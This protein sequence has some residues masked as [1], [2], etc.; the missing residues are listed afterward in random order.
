M[1]SPSVRAERESTAIF[2]SI[3]RS[4]FTLAGVVA[5]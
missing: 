4:G 2:G 3:F 1:T 5:P